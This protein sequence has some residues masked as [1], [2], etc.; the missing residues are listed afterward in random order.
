MSDAHLRE[1]E[2]ELA[3]SPGQAE[4][5]SALAAELERA[6][7][8]DEALWVLWPGREAASVRAALA[9]FPAWDP[10]QTGWLDTPPLRSQPSVRWRR[11]V[12]E[13][14]GLADELV[15][16]PMGIGCRVD[17]HLLVLEP[18]T[19]EVR[20]SASANAIRLRLTGEQ[21]TA[22]EGEQLVARELW[23]G[24][25]QQGGTWQ[26]PTPR[27]ASA[28]SVSSPDG[29]L[30]TR[31][32]VRGTL[33][34]VSQAAGHTI[35]LLRGVYDFGAFAGARDVTYSYVWQVPEGWLEEPTRPLGPVGSGLHAHGPHGE[36]LWY[37]PE[38]EL[39]T[40]LLA[41][42]PLAGRIYALDQH[43]GVLCLEAARERQ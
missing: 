5:R 19:G 20:W 24:R 43:G 10:P 28:S 14:L 22:S 4:L 17:G 8:R 35:V 2:R 7:R 12:A 38:A 32:G 26:G 25:V 36:Q 39:G 15:A 31:E 29:V 6:G 37:L 42:A 34:V 11:Q 9:R 27:P 3:G 21:L 41:L 16:S 33:E 23:S 1:L 13:P 18:D 30:T 40:G